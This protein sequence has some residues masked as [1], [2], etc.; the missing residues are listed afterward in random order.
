M[1]PGPPTLL[2]LALCLAQMACTQQGTLPK[3]SISAEPGSVVPWG[4]PVSIVCRGPAWV[5]TFRLEKDNKY[6]YSDVAVTSG[7]EQ[8]TEARFHITVLREDAVGRYRC[9]YQTE[10]GWSERSEALSLEGTE[11]AISALPT[12]P[13]GL[14]TE[15]V[16][17]LIGVSVAFL[18]C[19]FLLVLLLL[20]RQHRRKRGPPRSKDEEQRHQGRLSP[21]VDVLDGTPDVAS[22]DRFPDMDG[23]VGAST[24]AAGG[25][26]EV[27]YAQLNHK[28][29]TQRAARAVSPPSTE[30]LA[31][32]ST[33]ATIA[34]H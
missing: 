23:E 16:Y 21:A 9:I 7:G 4:R 14:S 26:Q 15:Q 27:T 19:L 32:S 24:P 28:P 20:H 11:E 25:L 1:A 6:N 3:P 17:I 18:L 33:Y 12:A 13:T 10:S 30:P 5:T 31:E 34:R 22:V 2:G 8:E 29:L